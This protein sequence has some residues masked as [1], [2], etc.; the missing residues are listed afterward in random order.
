MF[1]VLLVVLEP[2]TQSANDKVN[3]SI[4]PM[5]DEFSIR[6]QTH[7]DDSCTN[8]SYNSGR[9]CAGISHHGNASNAPHMIDSNHKKDLAGTIKE[10]MNLYT[11]P[12]ACVFLR[13]ALKLRTMTVLP[14]GSN[15]L[16]GWKPC[17]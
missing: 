16:N 14:G 7:K 5:D 6:S 15:L 3:F 2:P 12:C 10:I 1:V 4:N 17:S 11:S 13:Y 8:A 9:G